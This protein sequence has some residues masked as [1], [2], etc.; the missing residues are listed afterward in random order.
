MLLLPTLGA[1]PALPYAIID[2]LLESKL[3][4]HRQIRTEKSLNI[5]QG[6]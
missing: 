6:V 5:L 1:L 4:A 2:Y 3:D